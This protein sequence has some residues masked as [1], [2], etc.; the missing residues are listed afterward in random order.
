MVAGFWEP[1]ETVAPPITGGA[2]VGPLSQGG[3]PRGA[4]TGRARDNDNGRGHYNALDAQERGYLTDLFYRKLK[5]SGGVHFLYNTMRAD[6]KVIPWRK[7]VSWHK[8]QTVNQKSRPA[9]PISKS[10]AVMPRRQD[11]RILYKIGIDAIAMQ[12]G[13]GAD[14][15]NP[16]MAD[17]GRTHILN[18]IDYASRMAWPAAM[19]SDTTAENSRTIEAWVRKIR[20]DL[21]NDE[22]ADEWPTDEMIVTVDNGSTLGAGFRA[23]MQAELGAGV[24]VEFVEIQAYQPNQNAFVENSNKQV[25]N[26]LRRIVQA[27]RT[28]NSGN[29]TKDWRANWYGT[30]GHIFKQMQKLVNE[31]IDN[32]LGLKRPIDVWA[33]YVATGAGNAT[34]TQ[35]QL[36]ADTQQ[37]LVDDAVKRRGPSTL[38]EDKYF[39]PSDVVRRVN[40]KYVKDGVR[41]N[42]QKLGGRWSDE[43]YS[44]VQ[45][46]RARAAPG[47]QDR[48]PPS[49]TLRL[50]S[51]VAP[52]NFKTNA[53]GVSEK[54][55]SHDRLQKI[56]AEEA[57]PVNLMN[58][59]P[60]AVQMNVGDR[61]ELTYVPVKTILPNGNLQDNERPAF[62]NLETFAD[63]HSADR[64][65]GRLYPGTLTH[66][67]GVNWIVT[68]DDGST[69]TFSPTAQNQNNYIERQY[70][71]PL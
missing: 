62:R 24:A 19:R 48:A 68:M 39:S 15:R 20:S 37:A 30:N 8:S 29:P 66:K 51:G 59:T 67:A 17:R 27:N 36:I 12:G 40:D 10:L 58:P 46:F 70:W 69:A 2:I 63:V 53:G 65:N 54:R 71:D 3:R 25:R 38:K 21:Y 7:V 41:S 23:A 42:Y 18:I 34:A 55:F 64:A 52:A 50:N 35:T 44:I 5:A 1:I 11:M 6:G 60:P 9:K 32:A 56:I 16:T 26:V 13:T 14:P 61:L 28:V 4:R 49:Y 22:D 43:T 33:A 47:T 57:V 31:R 45:I